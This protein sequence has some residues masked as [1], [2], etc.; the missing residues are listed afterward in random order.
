MKRILPPYNVRLTVEYDGAAFHGYQYQPNVRTVQEELQRVLTVVLREPP[1]LLT[2]AGRT[3]A[4]V[5]ARGQVVNFFVHSEPDLTR[6]RY[7][8]S[9]MLRNELSVTSAEV[10]APSFDARRRA[11]LKQYTYLI[12][13]RPAP[14]V[15]EKGRVW[16]VAAPLNVE[17]MRAAARHLVG[18]H[19]FTSLRAANCGAHSPIR[20]IVVSDVLLE[21]S[22]LRY[23]VQ[24]KSFLKQMVRNIVGTLVAIG[25]DPQGH[26][27]IAEI[28]LQ[29]DRR[30][31]DVT[32]PPYGLSL[33]WVK[34]E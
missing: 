7:A 12:L 29:R 24:S 3:D 10:V 16:H 15:L 11:V 28:L 17:A 30:S 26:R 34:Y 8:V 14:P 32:A 9:S 2:A 5:H 6:L 18:T 21:G 27:S 20:T 1:V 13:N 25:R 4:G 31:A 33:D 19:D 23:V 22:L